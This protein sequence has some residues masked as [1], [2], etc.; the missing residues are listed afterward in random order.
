MKKQNSTVVLNC[1]YCLIKNYLA[2]GFY[3]IEKDKNY[4]SLLPNDV[5]LRIHLIARCTKHVRLPL[6]E[7]KFVASVNRI[8]LQDNQQKYTQ[9]K[10]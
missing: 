4:L 9:E 5:K 6:T 7:K 3:I 10:S 8:L 1:R 2:K